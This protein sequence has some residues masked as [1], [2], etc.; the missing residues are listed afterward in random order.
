MSAMQDRLVGKQPTNIIKGKKN[1]RVVFEGGQQRFIAKKDLAMWTKRVDDYWANKSGSESTEKS[2][3]RP[4]SS[5]TPEPKPKQQDGCCA[6]KG[7][8]MP[9]KKGTM[10]TSKSST[11]TNLR[12]EGRAELDYDPR[13]LA[14]VL[15]GFVEHARGCGPDPSDIFRPKEE[16]APSST[17]HQERLKEMGRE[18]FDLLPAAISF[19]NVDDKEWQQWFRRATPASCG[20]ARFQP[21]QPVTPRMPVD[22][23][24]SSRAAWLAPVAGPITSRFGDQRGNELHEGI[25]V[26]VPV[27]TSVVAPTTLQVSKVG[28]SQ[29][30]GRYIV[31]NVM[32]E[33]GDFDDG[34][35][36]R[37][38]FAHL[39]AIRVQE[40]EIVQRGQTLGQSGATGNVTGPHL[41]FRVQWVED[42]ILSDDVVA[43]DPLA[44]IPEAVFAGQVR[45]SV[46]GAQ[47][48]VGIRRGQ[49]INI[50]IAP[51]SG[52]VSA[53]GSG[54]TQPDVGVQLPLLNRAEDASYRLGQ[55]EVVDDGDPLAGIV[56]AAVDEA[57]Q[58]IR[59]VGQVAH[60]LGTLAS[61]GGTIASFI[62]GAAP[63]AA[64]VAAVGSAVGGV[65]RPISEIGAGVVEVGG[66][67]VKAA[68]DGDDEGDPLAGII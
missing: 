68:N 21:V 23:A 42:G 32:R 60:G 29:R 49:P 46:L 37:L 51:G 30:A 18:L 57:P 22:T 36:Y 40:G 8:A 33:G 20:P 31:A 19:F 52:R 13:D 44:V 50:V 43:I 67:L 5:R 58:F 41:H 3:P 35:G 55:P 4:P 54:L 25:D 64:P 47:Q 45:P 38:T 14:Y 28:F 2:K 17:P 48:S 66:R 7:G 26:A 9:T 61:V 27:G 34:D 59:N 10:T 1:Y 39:S 56:T 6:S 65:A 16:R 11:T 12:L 24:P 62:P 15:R 63:V 53:G